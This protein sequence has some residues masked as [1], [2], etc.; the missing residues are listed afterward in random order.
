LVDREWRIV[1]RNCYDFIHDFSFCVRRIMKR[2]FPVFLF[3]LIISG[4]GFSQYTP[5]EPDWNRPVEPFRIAGNIYYVGASDITSYLITSPKGHILIDSGFRETVPLIQ[6]NIIKLGF[7][8][9]DVKIILNSHA[10]YDHAG[11]I[12]ELKRL[13]KA[14]FYASEKDA[15]LLEK[16]GLGDP[17]YGDKYPFEPA[18]ADHILKNGQKIKLGGSVLQANFTP[19]HTPGCTT[20][21]TTV[22]ENKQALNVIFVCS[23]S[24]PGY[25]LVDNQKYP[26]IA[27]DYLGTFAWLKKQNV[28]IFLGAHGSAYDLE[29][30]LGKAAKNPAVNPFIDPQGY[31]TYI[32]ESERA[33]LEKLAAQ[34]V[35]KK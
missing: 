15:V 29:G 33:F 4:L 31:K 19:G 28:D 16:G 12:A 14:A 6:K 2:A 3:I 11:G 17:N 34:K 7:K 10:H 21:T 8:L 27:E 13:A 23:V 24:A 18:R 30:K 35:E 9:E 26:G 20:W 5:A 1:N 32:E 25:A 22:K